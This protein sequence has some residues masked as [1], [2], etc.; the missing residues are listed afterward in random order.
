MILKV[1][2]PIPVAQLQMAPTFFALALPDT[3][4]PWLRAEWGRGEIPELLRANQNPRHSTGGV[5]HVPPKLPSTELTPST[6]HGALGPWAVVP[7]ELTGAVPAHGS[8][9]LVADPLRLCPHQH[10]QERHP[11]DV[12]DPPAAIPQPLQQPGQL[13]SSPVPCP[14]PPRQG[15]VTPEVTALLDQRTN[16]RALKSGIIPKADGF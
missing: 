8:I 6:E 11:Q 13:Q 9:E 1:L 12:S 14:A 10:L 4:L 15:R 2:P 7:G 3:A 16:S 5:P